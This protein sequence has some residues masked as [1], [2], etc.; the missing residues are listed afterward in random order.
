MGSR[1]STTIPVRLNTAPSRLTVGAAAVQGTSVP[2]HGVVVKAICPGQT[3][4]VGNSTAVTTA[5]G[6]PLADGES[7]TFE[8]SNIN[9]LWFIASAALQSVALLPYVWN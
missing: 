8:V 7:I 4:Y 3:I 9:Q 2:C 5:T 6:Y 1:N